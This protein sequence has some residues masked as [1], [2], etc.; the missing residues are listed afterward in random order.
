MVSID[1]SF[2]LLKTGVSGLDEMLKGG[3]PEGY[4]VLVSGGPGSGKTILSIQFL[5]HGAMMDENGVYVSLDENPLFIKRN[6]L[7]SF[8]WDLEQ[9][10]RERKLS[11]IDATPIRYVPGEVKLGALTLGR[12][13][14]SMMTLI[15]TIKKSVEG[16]KAKRIAV[17]PITALIFQYPDASERRFAFMDLLQCLAETGC[18]SILSSELRVASLEREF[19]SEEY[20]CQGVLLLQSIVSGGSFTRVIQIEKM[21]GLSHDPQPRPYR[22]TQSGIVVY[23]SEKVL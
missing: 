12:R 1:S 17:D 2:R 10:E 6:M 11:I 18:T 16:I 9:L 20:L 19:Q 7:R 22:T 4:T 13:E 3:L 15:E 5:Y 23:P 14:F 21:R 8:G